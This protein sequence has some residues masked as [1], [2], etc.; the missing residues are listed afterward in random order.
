MSR[1]DKL[2]DLLVVDPTDSFTRYAIGLEFAKAENFVE[3]IRVLEDLRERDPE[4]VP[5]YYMLAGYYRFTGDTDSAK[6]IYREGMAMAK[7]A[8]DRHALSELESAL[9]EIE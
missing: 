9:D 8:N 1:L 6:L 2:Q 4:Y 5:T 7:K 3:A